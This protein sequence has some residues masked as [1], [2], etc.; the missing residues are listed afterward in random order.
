[1]PQIRILFLRNK[2]PDVS[3]SIRASSKPLA[4]PRS[5]SAGRTHG[6]AAEGQTGCLRVDRG[7]SWFYPE[8]FLRPATRERNP[9]DYRYISMG[10]RVAKSLP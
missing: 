3:C 4:I 6:A 9:P 8:R 1:M 2:N 10:F 5:A 7:G